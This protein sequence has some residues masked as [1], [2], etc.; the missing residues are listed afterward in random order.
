MSGRAPALTTVV[1]L[2]TVQR[3]VSVSARVRVS[4]VLAAAAGLLALGATLALGTSVLATTTLLDWADQRGVTPAVGGRLLALALT[5]AVTWLA[6]GQVVGE[7]FSDR[8]LAVA[9]SPVRGLWVALDC[10]LPQVVLGERV[11]GQVTRLALTGALTLGVAIGVAR[12]SVTAA[13]AVLVVAVVL[14]AGEVWVQAVA[15]AAAQEP[16]RRRVRPG[17]REAFWIALGIGIGA[18]C[19]LLV[20]G[21]GTAL[22]GTTA[23]VVDLGL[24]TVGVGALDAVVLGCAALAVTALVT[25][26]ARLRRLRR[27][28]PDVP[29]RSFD[30][31]ASVA[32]RWALGHPWRNG[33]TA[34]FVAV[35]TGTLH[36]HP[37]VQRSLRVVLMVTAA[38]VTARLVAGRAPLEL[39]GSLLPVETITAVG[40]AT[41]A[42]GIAGLVTIVAVMS[43]GQESRL[44]HYRTLWELGASARSLWW[45][46]VA[47]SLVQ[48]GVFGLVA[49][50]ATSVVLDRFFWEALAVAIV[51]PLSDY[52]A[53]SVCARPTDVD[54]DRRSTSAAIG[55]LQLGLSVPSIVLVAAGDP[56]TFLLPVH[57]A[58]LAL[59]GLLCF[60]RRLT[61]LPRPIDHAG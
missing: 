58:A 55:L 31:P 18:P 2:W 47:G 12:E 28:A 48:V 61:T 11:A 19:G 56:W 33:T 20:A 8:R 52:L 36:V 1:Q 34:G 37:V 6:L 40:A 46:H 53:E 3:L 24:V 26:L 16:P 10:P 39:E 41:V 43:S 59:G 45:G 27:A 44:W 50:I 4:T 38:V 54:G 13:A 5:A 60:S 35:G 49:T 25:G 42:A 14:V 21:N 22:T 17:P 51:V 9:T 29:L 32:E 15:L 7:R 30:D 57:V 23:Q